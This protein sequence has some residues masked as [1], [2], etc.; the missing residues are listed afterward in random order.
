[1][2]ETFTP[3]VC[4]SRN[5]Q[6][7]A[8][9]LF[10][11]SAVAAAAGL[12]AL[13]G[14]AGET[15]GAR[16]LVLAAAAL[17]LLAAAREAGL[18]RVPLPQAR[19]QVPEGWRFS[20]PLPV[21][22]MGYGGGLGAGFLTHQTV[23]TFWVACT[24]ALALARPLPAA[25]CL[26]LYGAGRAIMVVFPRRRP[27]DP[28]EAVERIAGRRGTVL[29][30]NVAALAAC[31]TLLALAPAAGAAVVAP[32]LDPTVDVGVLAWAQQDGS[33]RVRDGGSNHSYP[34]ASAPS[35]DGELLA[36]I[37]GEGIRIIRWQTGEEVRRLRTNAT[38]VALDWPLVAFRREDPTRRRLILRNLVKGSLSV[39]STVMPATDIGRPS[40]KQ[41]NLA[42]HVANRSGS[43]INLLNLS[44]RRRR[45]IAR[46][47]IGLLRSPAVNRNRI[48]WADERAGSAAI[49]MRYLASG[50]TRTV[51]RLS[52]RD[53]GFWSTALSSARVYATRWSR[54]TRSA[55]IYAFRY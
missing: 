22:A 47:A 2:L 10:A 51:A 5:R 16:R 14:L 9:L 49:R 44:S 29:R 23:S 4:G 46:T 20:L 37:D 53:L 28:T 54:Q 11:A 55:T 6:R 35:L 30:L 39:V 32:G 31:A 36:Y 33:V 12:G 26:S 7:A 52:S 48:V 41:G 1:M 42:W 18:V 40:L 24:G 27:D 15:F 38:A 13:L 43:R 17:A 3:A 25:L 19:R 8:S 45:T 34:N 21:W 50:S